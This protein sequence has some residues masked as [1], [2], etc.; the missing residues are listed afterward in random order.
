MFSH[1]R[2]DKEHGW[3]STGLHGQGQAGLH[4]G[5]RLDREWIQYAPLSRSHMRVK[6]IIEG[7][8][9]N[10]WHV[11]RYVCTTCSYEGVDDV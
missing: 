5:M 7:E 2:K 9:R 3:T 11:D 4:C 10:E 1:V 8:E 6:Q